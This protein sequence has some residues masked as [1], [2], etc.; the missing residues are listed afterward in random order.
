MAGPWEKYQAAPGAQP[1]DSQQTI[2]PAQSAA[3]PGPWDKFKAPAANAQVAEIVTPQP[4]AK[5]EERGM[6]QKVGDFFTGADRET[7]ATNELP[8]LQSSGLMAGLG[9]DDAKAAQISATIATTLDPAEI[10]KILQ[11]ASPDI[12]IQQDEKGNIIAANNK[13]GVRTVINKPGFSGMDAAQVGALGAAFA[14]AARAVTAGT[15]LAKGAAVLG[16]ASAA[17][18]TALQGA[19]AAA[20]G[21][22]NPEDVAL[23]GVAG[24]GGELVA[25]GVGAAGRA[26]GNSLAARATPS[27]EIIAA[28]TARQAGTATPDQEALLATLTTAGRL[29]RE[30]VARGVVDSA[31]IEGR[32]QTPKIDRLAQDVAPDESILAAAERLG[33]RD[34]LIPSQYSGSQA[35]REIEQGLASIPGSQLN[36]QQKEAY[37]SL[38]KKADELIVDYGGTID[39]SQLSDKFKQQGLANIDDLGNQSDAL[40]SQVSNAIPATTSSPAQSTV[41]YLQGKVADLGDRTLLSAAERRTLAALTRIDADGTPIPPTYAALDL[42]RK[43][44]GEGLR[45]RGPFKDS[46]SGALSRLYGTLSEDQQAVADAAGVGDLFATA[47]GLVA[48]RKGVEDAMKD[49]LGKDLSGALTSSAG[50]AVKQLGKGDFKRFDQLMSRLPSDMKQEVVLTALNDAFTAGSRAEK[51]LS[52]P[53]FVDWYEKLARN[54]AAKQRLD[55]NLPPDAVARLDDIFKVAKGMREASKERITTGRINSMKLLEDYAGE[56]GMLNRLWDV[57]KKV[58]AAEGATSGIGMPGVGTVGV[59]A[60]TLAKPKT[61]IQESASALLASPRFRDAVTAYVRSGG[62]LQANVRAQEKALMRTRAYQKWVSALSDESAARVSAV[63]PLAYLAEG[64]VSE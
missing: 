29:D 26:I 20:G 14:P 40:Y 58:G 1:A 33:I 36:T 3:T 18:E 62:A 4:A 31:T 48:Q 19:Q 13:T 54:P 25:R 12:G 51:Q 30:D 63:G 32:R 35:Y 50:N 49:V 41:G 57:S 52:A 39:K 5:P 38:A 16:A 59:L 17:T 10:G 34:Q 56:G 55:T 45:G 43:Q 46:E 37:G 22:F 27:E 2:I 64:A 6:L 61:P 60:T 23:S 44:I 28:N 11:S 53:G 47:K 15:G 7:R 24:A 9:L 21:D 42:V 8:E